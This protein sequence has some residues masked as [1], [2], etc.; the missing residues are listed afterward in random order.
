MFK[1][2]KDFVVDDLKLFITPLTALFRRKP[3]EPTDLWSIIQS[4]RCPDCGIKP[5]QLY[6]GPSGAMST[7]VFCGNCGHGYNI[8]PM[9]SLAED[10][11]VNLRYCTNEQMK[12]KRFIDETFGSLPSR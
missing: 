10:I 6:E 4:N 12:A 11:G 9:V 8:T 3:S 1:A 7:N 2:V 5:L